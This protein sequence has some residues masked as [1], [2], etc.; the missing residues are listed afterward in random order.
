MN[1]NICDVCS[2][3]S[4]MFHS[5]SE[6]NPVDSAFIKQAKGVVGVFLLDSM[7]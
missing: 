5:I 6:V 3:F 7:A 1:A 4:E 2:W